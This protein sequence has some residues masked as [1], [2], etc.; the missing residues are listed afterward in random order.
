MTL[1]H[2]IQLDPTA[3]QAIYFA[4]ACGTARLVWNFALAEWNQQYAIGGKPK[5]SEIKRYFNSIKYER[6]PWLKDVHRDAHS[7][8]FANLQ[9][10]F[11]KFFKKTAKYPRFKK[12]G[13]SRDSFYIANDK[14]KV[15]GRRITLPVVGSVRLT[16]RLRFEGKI[17]SAVVSRDADRWFVSITVEMPDLTLKILTGEPI[18]VDLGLTTFA[19]ISD[20]RKIVAPKPLAASLKRLR[21]LSE[22]HS[23]KRLGS[24]NRKKA[25][26]RLSRLHWRIRNIRNDFLHKLSTRL[27][28][29]HAEV[30]I[31]DLN[32]KGMVKNRHLSKAISD[33]GW[34]DFR[35]MLNYK[36]PL[37]GSTLTVRDRFFASS[38]LCSVCGY[39]LESLPLSV[40]T[41]TCLGCHTVHDRDDNA[42]KNLVRPNTEGYSGI[43]ASGQEGS[44]LSVMTGETGLDEGRTTTVGT[45]VPS[46]RR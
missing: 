40:R 4:K 26:L 17:Q 8:P 32:V 23:H 16:E 37:Y 22:Q 10:A 36:C 45:R 9:E 11:G 24:N 43:N 38:K 1:S 20:G 31:E 39:K 41:W 2:R 7:Q 28:K 15:N 3:K 46:H 29:N 35:S 42:S 30:C 13:K 25:T 21:R 12:K 33:A 18:G 6:F 44:D 19:T 5:A 14:F 34:R 27:C